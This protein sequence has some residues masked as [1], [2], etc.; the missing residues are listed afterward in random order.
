MDVKNI[1]GLEEGMI[2]FNPVHFNTISPPK[3]I[4]T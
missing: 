3:H 1:R 2:E 4:S